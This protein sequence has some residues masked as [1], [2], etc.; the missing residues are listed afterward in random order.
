VNTLA[1]DA[2]GS[3]KPAQGAMSNEG[4]PG[5]FH[6]TRQNAPGR[7]CGGGTHTREPGALYCGEAI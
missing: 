1:A 5:D 6:T 4:G 2:V 3:K 7:E